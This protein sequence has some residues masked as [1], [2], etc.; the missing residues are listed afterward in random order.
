MRLSRVSRVSRVGLGD[1]R[2]TGRLTNGSNRNPIAITEGD[3]TIPYSFFFVF[4]TADT[5]GY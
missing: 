2:G 4:E 5:S 1:T 3:S